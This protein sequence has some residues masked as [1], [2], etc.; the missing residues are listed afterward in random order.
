M[1]LLIISAVSIVL[2][3]QYVKYIVKTK[4]AMYQ[5]IP[6]IKDFF[7]ITYI[8]NSGISFGMLGQIDHPAKR[9]ILLGIVLLAIVMILVYWIKYGKGKPVYS[10]SCGLIIGG[11]LGN[12]IDRLVTGRIVDF[13][14][15]GIKNS[16]FPVFNIADSAVT[17]GVTI[18]I[19]YMLFSKEAKGDTPDA[20]DTVQPG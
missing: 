16:R 20:S 8:E 1:P 3:D 13:L 9:W 19:I 18:F 14:E 17:V 4:M 12:F 6:V 5:S 10:L 11:A 2:L 7:H 15:F